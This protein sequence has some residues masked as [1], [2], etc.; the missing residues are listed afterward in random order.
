MTRVEDRIVK[1]VPSL[2]LEEGVEMYKD[3]RRNH[4]TYWLVFHVMT[5]ELSYVQMNGDTFRSEVSTGKY[6]DSLVF[7]LIGTTYRL[8]SK[9]PSP[10]PKQIG[11]FII[12]VAGFVHD[13]DMHMALERFV[14]ENAD[15]IWNYNRYRFA[16]E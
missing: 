15:F 12:D 9:S 6:N 1:V 2:T 8:V 3:V 11:V 16:R 14:E 10:V 7:V 4:F 13:N 5:H